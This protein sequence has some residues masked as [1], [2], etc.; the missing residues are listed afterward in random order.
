[1]FQKSS[2]EKGETGKFKVL[3][4]TSKHNKKSMKTEAFA[5]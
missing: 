5:F 4:F 3:S 2:A 1:M